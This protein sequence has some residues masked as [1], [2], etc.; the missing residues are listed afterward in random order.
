MVFCIER[1][2]IN[3]NR[4]TAHFDDLIFTHLI[5]PICGC[6]CAVTSGCMCR[7]M[8]VDVHFVCICAYVFCNSQTVSLK[9]FC[10][11]TWKSTDYFTT[12]FCV[13]LPV[14]LFRHLCLL[15]TDRIYLWALLYPQSC[16]YKSSIKNVACLSHAVI[17]LFVI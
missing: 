2:P 11:Y 5:C 4:W 9:E 15:W 16:G 17:F 8:Q 13:T 3:L 1:L 12:Y 10:N 7:C 14:H 6:I